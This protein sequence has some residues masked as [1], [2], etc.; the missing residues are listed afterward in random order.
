MVFTGNLVNAQEALELGLVNKV[1]P[2]ESLSEQVILMCTAIMA[3]SPEGI[4]LAKEAINH[5]F[6]SGFQEGLSMENTIYAAVL[7][8]EDAHRRMRAFLEKRKDPQVKS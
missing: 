3:K 4:R 7:T 2:K 5:T 1:V 6:N 8:S